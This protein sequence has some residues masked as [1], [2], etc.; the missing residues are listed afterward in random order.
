MRK[1]LKHGFKESWLEVVI[2]NACVIV[3]SIVLFIGIATAQMFLLTIG[4]AVFIGA[5]ASAGVIILMSISRS[6]HKKLFTN[7]GYLTLTTPVSLDKLLLSKIIVNMIWIFATVFSFAISIFIMYAGIIILAGPAASFIFGVLVELIAQNPLSFILGIITFLASVLF[8]LTALLF[9][10]VLF[11]TGH[12]KRFKILKGILLYYAFGI[13]FT[14]ISYAVAYFLLF[15]PIT[16]T[17][18]TIVIMLGLS[19]AFY[20]LS[21]FVIMRKLELE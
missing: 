14:M 21:R 12:K 3:S 6:F 9:I 15:Y 2:L 13:V 10:I 5:L 18:V 17:V 20:F 7:E 16:R 8:F 19:V 1:L 4:T 11:N